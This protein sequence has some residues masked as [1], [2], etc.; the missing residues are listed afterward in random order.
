MNKGEAVK[1]IIENN[2]RLSKNQA[3]HEV[4]DLENEAENPYKSAGVINFH[5]AAGL[6]YY[7]SIN[8]TFVL[9]PY[10]RRTLNSITKEDAR[11]RENIRYVGISFGTRVKF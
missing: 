1:N 4:L 9:T 5:L 10:Y 6:T 11:F 3:R 2:H 7:H 8:T